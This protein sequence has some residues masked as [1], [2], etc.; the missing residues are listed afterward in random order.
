VRL[1]LRSHQVHCSLLKKSK[2]NARTGS[3]RQADVIDYSRDVVAEHRSLCGSR[4][5]ATKKEAE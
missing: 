4:F 1:A 2:Y 5:M 3:V